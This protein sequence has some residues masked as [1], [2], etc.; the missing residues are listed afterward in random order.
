MLDTYLEITHSFYDYT[1]TEFVF[2][3]SAN[4][5]VYRR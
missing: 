5:N 4:F 2:P 3:F 1:D